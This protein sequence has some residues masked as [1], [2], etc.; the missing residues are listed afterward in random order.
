M[1]APSD[2]I[3]FALLFLDLVEEIVA[4]RLRPPVGH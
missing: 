1:D 4:P 2:D 3:A